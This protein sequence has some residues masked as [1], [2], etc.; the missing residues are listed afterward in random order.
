MASQMASAEM[1]QTTADI[2]VK[3]RD[4]TDYSFRAS[5]S[6]VQFDGFLKL[7]EVTR[8]DDDE[9]ARRLP[10]LD[11]KDDAQRQEHR[12][13]TALH[14]AAAPG[15]PSTSLI[16]RMEEL[17]I[18]RPSTYASTTRNPGRTRLRPHR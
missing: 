3:G 13:R 16:K 15:S 7:Y 11:A 14:Q 4:G 9:D 18:G 17:G 2:A 5:G 12:R 6:V 1:E 10:N 8:D